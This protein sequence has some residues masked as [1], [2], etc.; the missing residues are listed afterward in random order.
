MGDL[1]KNINRYEV[2]CKCGVCSCE[3]I[4]IKTAEVVQ[5]AC[6]H[7]ADKLGFE[8]VVLTINSAHRCKNH[9]KYVGGAHNSKHLLGSAVDIKIRYV[10]P[11]DL[12]EY[13]DKKH[14]RSLGIGLY[15]NFVHVDSRK[16]KARW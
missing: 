7:F 9:N 4:D 1:T 11:K 14:S 8:R 2:A 15:N 10:T 13:L 16:E 3:T 6:D 5:D 12:Y